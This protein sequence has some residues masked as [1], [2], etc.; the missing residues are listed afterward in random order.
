M[1]VIEI[2]GNGRHSI[3]PL[4]FINLDNIPGESTTGPIHPHA[5]V[6]ARLTCQ[7]EKT[8][9]RCEWTITPVLFTR[10]ARIRLAR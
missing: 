4:P 6:T 2:R 3:P 8:S 10:S 1:A 7:R 9:A 5:A